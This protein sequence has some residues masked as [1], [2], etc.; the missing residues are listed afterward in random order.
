MKR[1]RYIAIAAL[2]TACAHIETPTVIDKPF[3]AAPPPIATVDIAPLDIGLR[4]EDAES[5]TAAVRSRATATLVNTAIDGLGKRSY[6]VTRVLKRQQ[7]STADATL[8]IRGSSFVPHVQPGADT[9]L[10]GGNSNYLAWRSQQDSCATE[11]TNA[12]TDPSK[13][14]LEQYTPSA[15]CSLLSPFPP[16]EEPSAPVEALDDN[17]TVG[18]A[19]DP[20][21]FVTMS[22]W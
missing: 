10:H 18:D 17:A 19:Q 12:I 6:T 15:T 5:E 2:L 9:M 11:K 22:L 8:Y 16:D 14:E 20:S 3:P 21:L 1:M 4:V 7:K 13:T